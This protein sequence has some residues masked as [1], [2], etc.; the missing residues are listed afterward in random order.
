MVD[1]DRLRSEERVVNSV[2]VEVV[3]TMGDLLSDLHKVVRVTPEVSPLQHTLHSL[4]CHMRH[5]NDDIVRVEVNGDIHE[6]LDV[7][8][9]NFLQGVDVCFDF[10]PLMRIAEVPSMR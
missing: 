7:L 6:E 2:G 4:S 3:Q 9:V 10:L 5:E 8:V 1:C